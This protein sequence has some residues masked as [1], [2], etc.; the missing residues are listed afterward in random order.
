MGAFGSEG[1]MGAGGAEGLRAKRAEEDEG[2]A[3]YILLD[4][5][6]TM[7]IG[8]MALWGLGA[9]CGTGWALPIID[10]VQ[11]GNQLSFVQ[12]EVNYRI[13]SF[14]QRLETTPSAATRNPKLKSAISICTGGS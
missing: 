10:K 2:A 12:R 11:E 9:K 8:Y 7:G 3:I 1:A 14:C 4:C 5:F 13:G 6:D